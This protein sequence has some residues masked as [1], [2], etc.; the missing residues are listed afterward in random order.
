MST[1][2][3]DR[4]RTRSSLLGRYQDQYDAIDLVLNRSIADPIPDDIELGSRHFGKVRVNCCLR[5]N[6]C[7]WGKYKDN[8]CVVLQLLTDPREESGFKLN[9][10]TVE[11]SFTEHDPNLGSVAPPNERL[12]LLEPPLPRYLRGGG[13]TQHRATEVNVQP[14]V[15]TGPTG[16]QAGQ[17]RW[18]REGDV[19]D[20]WLY[21]SHWGGGQHG[22]FT[23]A[24][25]I[26]K[27][28][29]YN[30]QPEDVSHLYSGVILRHPCQPFWVGCKIQGQLVRSTKAMLNGFFKFGHKDNER[31]KFTKLQTR[32]SSQ[33][34]QDDVNELDDQIVKLILDASASKS[35]APNLM[36]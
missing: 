36:F 19:R 31:P 6:Y 30:P 10:L 1:T 12:R 16:V 3:P 23:V 7:K 25:W 20:Y 34:L 8:D 27:A 29:R 4:D 24:T 35:I 17:I 32:Q 13:T 33:D 18:T 26:W 14:Q 5:G 2:I 21:Q 9:N 22:S 15:T 28:N 11:L